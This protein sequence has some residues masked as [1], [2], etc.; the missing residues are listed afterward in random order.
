[1]KN[2]RILKLVFVC[3]IMAAVLSLA[4]QGGTS[5]ASA[6]ESCAYMSEPVR[7]LQCP[8]WY[9]TGFYPDNCWYC[10]F[11]YVVCDEWECCCHYVASAPGR[12]CPQYCYF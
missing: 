8:A 12:T 11:S 4:P 7:G 1:M 9:R 10:N 5:P 2:N 6:Q 3:L